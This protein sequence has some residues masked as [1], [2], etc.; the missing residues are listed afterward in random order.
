[1]KDFYTVLV[2]IFYV[3]NVGE[4][5]YPLF[6]VIYA[7]IKPYIFHDSH[8]ELK[9]MLPEIFNLTNFFCSNFMQTHNYTSLAEFSAHTNYS[10]LIGR[11]LMQQP[12]GSGI[13]REITE[14]SAFWFP[15]LESIEP[16]YLSHFQAKKLMPRQLF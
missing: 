1:M 4:G 2:V 12:Y 6:R 10:S 9:G 13:M 11:S 16:A 8:G 7:E 3:L 5:S 14:E 15:Y